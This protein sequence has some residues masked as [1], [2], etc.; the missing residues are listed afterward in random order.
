MSPM[1]KKLGIEI[2]VSAMRSSKWSLSN[3]SSSAAQNPIWIGPLRFSANPSST[4]AIDPRS[5]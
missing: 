1:A 5:P 3:A 4:F 2:Q